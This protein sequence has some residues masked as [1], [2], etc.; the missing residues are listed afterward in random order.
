MNLR[1]SKIQ[2]L[3]PLAMDGDVDE[4][5]R[6][7]IL[8]HVA[9]CPACAE[10]F[11][12]HLDLRGAIENGP[13]SSPPAVYF[14]GVLAEIHRRLPTAPRDIQTTPRRRI[15]PHSIASAA[16]AAL[17]LIWVGAVLGPRI[18]ERAE[19]GQGVAPAG[20]FTSSRAVSAIGESVQT[21]VA[22][23]AVQGIGL[24]R[25]DSPI[26][27]MPSEMRRELGLPSAIVQ[28]SLRSLLSKG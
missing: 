10:A 26:L 22:L 8:A 7:K 19:P 24:V 20:R 13:A 23:A 18:P 9:G 12:F 15:Q 17:A 14:E 28:A 5:V 16:A 2:S 1:C 3:V 25:A 27:R 21:A 11:Q 4:H 6:A